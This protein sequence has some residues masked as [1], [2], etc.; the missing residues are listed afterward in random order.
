LKCARII[1]FFDVLSGNRYFDIEVLS[2]PDQSTHF[3]GGGPYDRQ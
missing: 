1:C 2:V 3:L